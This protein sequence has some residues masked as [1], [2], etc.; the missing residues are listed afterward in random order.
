MNKAD[1]IIEGDLHIGGQEH[2][3]L[4][5]QGALARPL[6]SDEI[7]ITATTQNITLLQKQVS[8]LLDIP[9]HKVFGRA[10]RLGGGFGGKETRFF[11]TV[12]PVSLAAH[13]LGRPVR[14]ILD[15]DQDMLITGGRNPFYFKY[16]IG[17]RKDGKIVSGDIEAFNNAGYSIDLSAHVLGHAMFMVDGA[18]FYPNLRVKGK[19]CRTN[20]PSNTAFRAFGAPQA[21][22]TSETI[23][24]HIART[25]GKDY[26]EVMCLN[27]YN[28]GDLTHY[29]QAL[30][31]LQLKR[32]FDECLEQSKFQDQRKSVQE[33]NK[34]N[35]YRKRGVSIVPC[36]YGVSFGYAA[37]HQGAALVNVYLDGT[38]LLSHGGVASRVLQIPIEL[39]HISETASDKVP[40]TTTT[41]A[42]LTSDLNGPAVVEACTKILNRIKP[43]KEQFPNESWKDWV[44]RAYDDRISLSATGFHDYNFLTYDHENNEGRFYHYYIC[45]VG[46]S[47]VEIDCL[48]GDHK[49]LS[50]DIVMDIGSSLN[51]AIDIGQIEGA[52]MQGYGLFTMEELIY[53]QDGTLLSRGPGAYKIPGFADIP[54]AF[55][56][57][58]LTGAPNPRAIYSSKAIGEPPLFI[59]AAPYFA[60][61]EAISCYRKDQGLSEDFEFRS[62]AS[63]ARI[64]MACED[65]LTRMVNNEEC[66]KEWNILVS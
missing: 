5:P 4:E 10:K 50:T 7:E 56:V 55:N 30:E 15:R 44:C 33:F 9:Y 43:Y 1:H 8:R 34:L 48:T 19:C 26:T 37:A 13:K 40:N 20:L 3:Y 64:R 58:I 42:S 65:K 6:D 57:T 47:Q 52:F 41:A 36:K 28:T 45:G 25:V 2:F 24:R 27:M 21:M 49:V 35:K 32:C 62:P 11:L 51:P 60:I 39:I 14:C 18:Y 23:I 16:K 12:L 46:V 63:A 22:L 53:G 54:E 17:V 59:G 61:K 29:N 66:G 31:N 38:V